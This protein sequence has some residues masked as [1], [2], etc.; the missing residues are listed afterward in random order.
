MISKTALI[1][2]LKFGVSNIRVFQDE[3]IGV[4]PLGSEEVWI[5]TGIQLAIRR[6][7]VIVCGRFITAAVAGVSQRTTTMSLLRTNATDLPSGEKARHARINPFRSDRCTDRP[8]ETLCAL[9]QTSRDLLGR[10]NP[11][12]LRFL[13]QAHAAEIGVR[14]VQAGS[15]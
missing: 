11:V 3:A 13:E 2:E 7:C 10:S 8:A 9:S 6:D 14:A 12:P 1:V 5:G 15:R 4:D